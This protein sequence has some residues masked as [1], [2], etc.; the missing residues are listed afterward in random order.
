MRVDARRVLA[1]AEELRDVERRRLRA[2]VDADE[3]IAHDLHADDYQ[4]I[5]PGGRTLSKD[6][7]LGD[8]ATR[9]IDYRIFEPAS[10]IAVQ[11]FGDA[12]VVRYQARIDIRFA[13]GGSD[14]GLFWHTDIYRRVDRRWQAV[15]SQATRIPTET[16]GAAGG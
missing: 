2:L 7:Y 15:W 6:Q 14:G 16:T 10:A 1:Q 8:I 12:G 11:I 4:L 9:A 3:A 13:S 5:T